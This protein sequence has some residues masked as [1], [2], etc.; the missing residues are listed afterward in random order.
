M[1]IIIIA[2]AIAEVGELEDI[3]DQYDH[4]QTKGE[5]EKIAFRAWELVG[6]QVKSMVSRAAGGYKL[7]GD[8]VESLAWQALFNG[9]NESGVSRLRRSDGVWEHFISHCRQPGNAIG[10]RIWSL[11]SPELRKQLTQSQ[12]LKAITADVL[13]KELNVLLRRRDL[14]DPGALST[15]VLPQEAQQLLAHG[16]ENL[17]MTQLS[18]FNVLAL[19][20]AFPQIKVSPKPPRNLMGYISASAIPGMMRQ[21]AEMATGQLPNSHLQ[22]TYNALRPDV[23]VVKTM[24]ETGTLSEGWESLSTAEQIYRQQKIRLQ[25]QYGTIITWWNER[26]RE[27]QPQNPYVVKDASSLRSARELFQQHSNRVPANLWKEPNSPYFLPFSTMHPFGIKS[28]ENMLAVE[29][30]RQYSPSANPRQEPAAPVVTQPEGEQAQRLLQGGHQSVYRFLVDKLFSQPG[31]EAEHAVGLFLTQ[32]PKPSKSQVQAFISSLPDDL[33]DDVQSSGWAQVVRQVDRQV[34]QIL[35]DPLTRRQLTQSLGTTAI[36]RAR[37]IHLAQNEI[38]MT[39]F[40][41]TANLIAQMA[42]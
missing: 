25:R 21:I 24:Q 20:A 40:I 39:I 27:L 17:G 19:S 23:E 12:Y 3:L 29:S 15:M 38:R 7:D 6:D 4:A 26:I 1:P 32:N 42:G 10:Q 13:I 41:R 11:L 18:R 8:Q 2:A 9:L 5:R 37:A 35:Q 31:F 14:F 16:V 28:I 30:Q 36:A 34:I 33:A 22:S